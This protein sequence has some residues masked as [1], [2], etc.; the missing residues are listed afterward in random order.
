MIDL[1]KVIM[2]FVLV[3]GLWFVMWMSHLMTMRAVR[4]ELS[5][6]IIP[7]HEPVVAEPYFPLPR[8]NGPDSL[9]YCINMVDQMKAGT[10]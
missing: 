4:I 8:L 10:R 3:A 2:R 1:E 9:A 5:N 7:M 6:M